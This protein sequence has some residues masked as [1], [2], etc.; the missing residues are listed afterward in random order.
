MVAVAATLCNNSVVY[1]CHPVSRKACTPACVYLV[2]ASV[3]YS[4][5]PSPA[6]SGFSVVTETFI[7]GSGLAERLSIGV[8]AASGETVSQGEILYCGTDSV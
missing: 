8:S 1:F 3:A 2:L 5:R 4:F 7:L 6:S